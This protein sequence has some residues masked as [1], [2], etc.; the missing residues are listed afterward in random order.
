MAN[1]NKAIV[2]GNLGADPELRFTPQG[3]AVANFRIAT[4]EHWTDKKSGKL[5]TRTEWHRC[6]AWGRT[7]EIV[8]E[9]LTKGREVTVEGKLKTRQWKDRDGNT[10]YTT[11]IHCLPTGVYFHGTG[12]KQQNQKQQS[13]PAPEQAETSQTEDEPPMPEDLD[14]AMAELPPDL[15]EHADAADRYIKENS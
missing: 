9:Y 2:S 6:V 4:N 14:E 1:M 11:E 13:K 7:A 12:N 10:R 5:M 15:Q 8:G 3:T